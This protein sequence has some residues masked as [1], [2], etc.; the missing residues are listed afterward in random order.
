MA[1]PTI[2]FGERLADH[3]ARLISLEDGRKDDRKSLEGIRSR[4]D[5]FQF[6]LMATAVTGLLGLAAQL[7]IAVAFRKG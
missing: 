1:A 3:N 7:L 2:N 6:W 4:L 5:T